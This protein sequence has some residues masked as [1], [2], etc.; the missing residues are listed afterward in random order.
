MR[1]SSTDRRDTVD[2]RNVLLARQAIRYWANWHL[3]GDLHKS[4]GWPLGHP[5]NF[6]FSFRKHLLHRPFAFWP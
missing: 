4:I 1:Q 2:L 5:A 3:Q 6:S